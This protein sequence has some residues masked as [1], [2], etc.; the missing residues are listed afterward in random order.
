MTFSGAS[1]VLMPL[2][3]KIK[4]NYNQNKCPRTRFNLD[5]PKDPRITESFD[6]TVVATCATLNLLDENFNSP[7]GTNIVKRHAP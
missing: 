2:Q 5:Q 7:I 3:M 6:A 4:T 1:I